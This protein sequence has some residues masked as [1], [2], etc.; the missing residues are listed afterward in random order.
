MGKETGIYTMDGQEGLKKY[1]MMRFATTLMELDR[2]C[3]MNPARRRSDNLWNDQLIKLPTWGMGEG[4]KMGDRG[5]DIMMERNGSAGE[6]CGV[7]TLCE[8]ISLIGR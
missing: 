7:E 8:W 4:V 1:K 2:F 6:E 5:L 3:W